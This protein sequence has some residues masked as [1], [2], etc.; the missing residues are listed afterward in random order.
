[1]SS[2]AV[3]SVWSGA[4]GSSGSGPIVLTESVISYLN[5][6]SRGSIAHAKILVGSSICRKPVP[7]IVLEVSLKSRCTIGP[8]VRQDLPGHFDDLHVLIIN[9]YLTLEV[10]RL[11][12]GP[13]KDLVLWFDIEHKCVQVVDPFPPDIVEFILLKHL[14]SDVESVDLKQPVNRGDAEKRLIRQRRFFFHYLFGGPLSPV[15]KDMR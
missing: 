6:D 11:C 5:D 2:R 9:P 3:Q 7:V 13:G 14:G 15:T 8:G 12:R 1:M 10:T 4:R